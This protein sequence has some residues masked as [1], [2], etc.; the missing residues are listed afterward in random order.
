MSPEQSAGAF[1][2]AGRPALAETFAVAGRFVCVEAADADAARPFRR[3]FAGWHFARVEA[4]VRP[5]PDAVIR[6]HA[7]APPHAP[8]DLETFETA[9]GGL[10]R[11]DGRTYIFERDGSAVR[12]DGGRSGVDVWI[13]EGTASREGSAL[14]R[15]VFEA[16]MVALRRCGLFELHAAGVVEPLSGGGFLVAGP[17]GSGKSTL[18]TQLAS[19]GWRYLSDDA[20]LLRDAGGLVE[21]C[22]LRRDF[23]VT[24][25]T[26]AAGVLG[27]FE[28]LLTEPMPFD[29]LKRRFKPR[30][31]FPEGFAE[32]CAPRAI[33]FPVI[34]EEASSRARRLTQP[35]TMRALL[36]MCPWACYDKP[37]AAAHLALL[38][39]LARQ[40]EGFELSA[41][42]DLFGD[43]AY[44][45]EYL[46]GL[47]QG[48]SV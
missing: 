18:A 1:T 48:E 41:G 15:V 7:S 11:T 24:E 36:R 2:N 37:S 10:C 29:P 45:S 44:S 19:A 47:A 34:T 14:A 39:L 46:R 38:A 3:F 28:G 9:G 35:E 23:A 42:R 13:G 27:G 17:S 30:D 32:S 21:A 6:V 22:A 31:V 20:L 33:F 8:A 26:V 12:A 5:R 16:T 40:A 25:Q 4:A 43:G